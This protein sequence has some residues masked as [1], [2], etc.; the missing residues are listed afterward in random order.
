MERLVSAL[1]EKGRP[2][3]PVRLRALTRSS[4]RAGFRGGLRRIPGLKIEI[5]APATLLKKTVFGGDGA[6]KDGES[7]SQ[8]VSGPGSP[9]SLGPGLLASRST[10]ASRAG[11][12]N[13]ISVRDSIPQGLKP[14][15]LRALN[16]TAEAVPFQ[17]AIY[18]ASSGC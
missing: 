16:G 4:L 2:R 10:L 9:G 15:I 13:A 5:G 11:S 1:A 17:I 8:R 3:V 12:I 14:P 18:A 6:P 7:A